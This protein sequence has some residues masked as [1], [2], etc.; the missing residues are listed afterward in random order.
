VFS[1]SDTIVPLRP[2]REDGGGIKEGEEDE[3]EVFLA[4][5]PEDLI[6]AGKFHRVPYITGVNSREANIYV[7]GRPL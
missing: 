1:T 7:K 5:K 3:E 2:T 6:A 4:A